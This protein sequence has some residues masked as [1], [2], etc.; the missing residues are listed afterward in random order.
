MYIDVHMR[1]EI[2]EELVESVIEK[3][4]QENKI[5]IDVPKSKIIEEILM[6]YLETTSKMKVGS[7]K[8]GKLLRRFIRVSNII[9]KPKNSSKSVLI[10]STE[11]GSITINSKKYNNDVIISYKDV[12]K[13]GR[14][15]SRHL[16]SKRELNFLLENDP[17]IIVI[18]N[19]QEGCLQ[20]SPDVLNLAKQKNIEII[21]AATPEAVKK[22]N[23][24]YA[25]GRKVVG[26]MHVTC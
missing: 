13:E 3:W 22:F 14:T 20:V 2:S 15:Q 26:Y 6:K 25:S 12:V 23:Q 17:D 9:K 8:K 16:I 18:G 5:A 1:P 10:N 24:L 19:G 21:N 7:D 11:F 4:K